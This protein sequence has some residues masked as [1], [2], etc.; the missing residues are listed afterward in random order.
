MGDR[1]LAVNK[2]AAGKRVVP[3]SA[4]APDI[5]PFPAARIVP[6]QIGSIGFQVI[7]KEVTYE[8]LVTRCCIDNFQC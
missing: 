7:K 1:A 4:T 3:H 5:L 8:S 2:Y 6:I